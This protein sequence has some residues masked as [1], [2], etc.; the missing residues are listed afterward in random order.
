MTMTNQT[1]FCD[2]E[3]RLVKTLASLDGNDACRS[4]CLD[5][6]DVLGEA[7]EDQCEASDAAGDCGWIRVEPSTGAVVRE[8]G[9]RAGCVRC[10]VEAES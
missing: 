8:D 2:A 6:G 3:R 4:L 10:Y 7:T 1:V 9:E 5:G